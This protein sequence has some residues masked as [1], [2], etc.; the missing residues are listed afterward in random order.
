MTPIDLDILVV[1]LF[2]WQLKEKFSLRVTQGN[3]TVETSVKIESR[4]L[5]LSHF[6]L[7]FMKV[8]SNIE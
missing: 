8:L 4:I 3:L 2:K 7:P 5:M 6:L 1:T